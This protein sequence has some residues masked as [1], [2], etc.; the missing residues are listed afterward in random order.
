M[1]KFFSFLVGLLILIVVGTT[2]DLVLAW[3]AHTAWVKLIVDV[4]PPALS[5]VFGVICLVSMIPVIYP[6]MHYKDRK[7]HASEEYVFWIVKYYGLLIIT[8]PLVLLVILCFRALF[9]T[10]TW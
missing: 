8:S 5:T 4:P 6:S 1:S 7:E 2:A 3:V 10:G 9:I